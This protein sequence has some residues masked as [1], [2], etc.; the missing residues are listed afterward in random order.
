METEEYRGYTIEIHQDDYQ[1]DSPRDWGTL[2]TMICWHS[3]HNL[4]DAHNYKNFEELVC[5][6]TGLDEDDFEEYIEYQTAVNEKFYEMKDKEIFI[7]DLYLYDHS[8]IT[9]STSPFSCPWD[10]GQVGFIY[11]TKEKL[12]EEGLDDKTKEEIYKYL[13]GE[14]ETYDNFLT[15]NIYGYNIE[16]TGDSCWG[17]YGYD[18]EKSGLLEYA[19]S[20][21]DCEI[22]KKIKEKLKEAEKKHNQIKAWIRHKVPFGYRK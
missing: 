21:I 6:L 7:L 18:H 10:S 16:E 4:G 11:V 8:G 3:R 20:S 13:E 14:V 19:K 12:K 1:D 15:G 2:G 17:F 9:M 22:E 5:E